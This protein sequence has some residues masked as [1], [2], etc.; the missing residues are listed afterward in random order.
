M[1]KSIIPALLVACLAVPAQG[2]QVINQTKGCIYIKEYS[3]I[4]NRYNEHILSMQSGKCDPTSPQC[5]GQ[6]DL[7]VIKHSDGSDIQMEEP[8]CT[9]AGDVGTGKGHF[10][11]TPIAGVTPGEEGSCKIQYFP[12]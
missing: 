5:N 4:F 1:M 12:K 3:H 2:F 9:W 6:L 10:T 8:V 7:R 11:V